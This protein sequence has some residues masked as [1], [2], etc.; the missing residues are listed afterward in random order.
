MFFTYKGAVCWKMQAGMGDV[1]F[2]PLYEVL[3]KRGVTFRFFEKVEELALSADGARIGSIR[4]ARQATVRGGEYHPLVRVKGIDC[5]PD[6][7][8]YEQLVEGD[9]LRGIDL[10]SSHSGW[11][12]VERHTLREGVDFDE[13]ILGIPVGAL[14]H[15]CKPLIAARR[16]WRGMVEN[17]T[18]VCTHAVQLWTRPDLAALGWT[19]PLGLTEAPLLGA[20]AEPTDTWSDMTHLVPVEDWP[21]AETPGH[22]AYFCGPLRD[23]EEV[24]AAADPAFPRREHARVAGMARHFLDHDVHRLWPAAVDTSGRFRDDLLVEVGGVRA[25]HTQFIKANVEPTDR[26]TLSRKGTIQHRLRADRSGFTNLFLAG[27]W[28]DNGFNAGCVEATVMSGMQCARAVTGA[29]IWIHGENHRLRPAGQQGP[30]AVVD[31]ADLALRGAGRGAR[32]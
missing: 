19:S 9:A 6:R 32:G 29:N 28:I 4:M 2:T 7:P 25:L 8:L 21:A 11:E 14:R 27:D 24:P 20:Y 13:V 22:V 1:V 16:E 15:I 5:W 31:R 12:P 26:Y 30:R 18:T 23:P 3:R 17:V 10:E